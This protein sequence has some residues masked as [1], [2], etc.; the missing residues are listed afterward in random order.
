MGFGT[1][2]YTA[3]SG[4]DAMSNELSV[5]GNN[6]ANS[7]TVGFKGGT[8]AFANL[9]STS[10]GGSS[11]LSAGSGVAL[12]SIQSDFSQGTLQS[13]SNPLDMALQ[14]TGFFIVKSP[15]GSQYY[16][17]AGQFSVDENG[18]IVDP[19]GD[20]LQ[21]AIAVQQPTVTKTGTTP[22][23]FGAVGDINISNI[24][25][26]S[27]QATANATI[28]ASLPQTSA[29]DTTFTIGSTNDKICISTTGVAGSYTT[30]D[31][32]NLG[33]VNGVNIS[34]DSITAGANT[35][36]TVNT[37]I[38]ALVGAL[39]TGATSTYSAANYKYTITNPA[40]GTNPLYINWDGSQDVSNQSAIEGL[41]NMLGFS[42]TFTSS[43]DNVAATGVTD[44]LTATGATVTSDFQVAGFDPSNPGSDF[45]T[46][47]TVYDSSGNNHLINVYF[48]KVATGVA[49]GV[50]TGLPATTGT[51]WMWYATVPSAD[52]I[53]GQTQV[54][55]Q[56][57]LEFDTNSDLVDVGS[58]DYDS[59]NFS[60]GVTQNQQIVFDYGQAEKYDRASG[61][62]GTLGTTQFGTGGVGSISNQYQDGYA[63]GSLNSFSISQ[64]GIITGTFTNG[65]TKNIAQIE[66]ARFNAPT[67]LTNVGNNLYSESATSG[68]PIPGIA[69][70][71][72]FGKIYSSSLE[73]SN[74][75]L[76]SEF[77]NMITV[78][79]AYEASAKV[80]S[81]TQEL[82]TALSEAKQ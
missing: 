71:A 78:Q 34:A 28:F 52:S 12:E 11:G 2:L 43:A 70:S 69:G 17:R 55:A 46:T 63:A 51:R 7:S 61:G 77:V 60:G 79:S 40:T 57:S 33:T 58:Q 1:A 16:T 29:A 10:L 37:A 64:T 5:I 65:Q 32:T 27:P 20:F 23:T 41:S 30:Y 26:G 62:S 15:D 56:G 14:G 45:S 73:E 18:N 42:S 3:V 47:M 76:S 13:T 49:V 53:N 9:L 21:G 6:I 59:F 4:L 44:E 38:N 19:N 74:I 22:G 31:L 8:T 72:G 80:I 48:Q 39:S 36:A 82:F 54:A 35:A 68:Q 24:G 81:T 67:Q 50:G 66:L 75:D 25:I